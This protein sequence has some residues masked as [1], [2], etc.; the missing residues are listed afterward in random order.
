MKRSSAAIL[1]GVG[2]DRH[3]GGRRRSLEV[4]VGKDHVGGL[5]AELERHALD[6]GGGGGG[7]E[8]AHAG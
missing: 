6:R 5:A 4:S 3:R 7:D 1:A 2:E 8:T